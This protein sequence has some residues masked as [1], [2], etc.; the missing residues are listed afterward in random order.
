MIKVNFEI[1]QSGSWIK[2]A[3]RFEWFCWQATID[4][5]GI[6]AQMSDNEQVR[7]CERFWLI[8]SIVSLD[9]P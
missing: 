7:V 9:L 8:S 1:S 5:A 4:L 3:K 6:F 2:L